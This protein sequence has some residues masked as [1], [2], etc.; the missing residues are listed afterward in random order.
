VTELIELF[1]QGGEVLWV[2]A[3]LSVVGW[4]LV[5]CKFFNL[6]GE[7]RGQVWWATEALKK[8]KIGQR[9][10]A[11]RLCRAEPSA[12]G[13]VLCFALNSPDT[14]NVFERH[15]APFLESE[16][17]RLRRSLSLIAVIAA[18]LP[19]LGLLGT[20]LGMVATFGSITVHG[21]S[22]PAALANGVSQA[23]ITT[24]AGLVTGL[25]ILLLHGWLCSRV[26][27]CMD[28]ATLFAKKVESN[29]VRGG[30]EHVPVCSR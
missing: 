13:R 10:E 4:A 30:L 28:S 19:L 21:N 5:L 27:A 12:L 14:R 1:Q 7:H 22:D 25:P 6:L 18:T 15:Y 3:A 16:A 24:Q 2:I 29:R 8:L 23:L 26:E 17:L 11:L 9:Q 20:V